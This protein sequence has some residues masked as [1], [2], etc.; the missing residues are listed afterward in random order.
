VPPVRVPLEL[1]LTVADVLRAVRDDARPFALVGE[2]ADSR[3]IVSS[4]PVRVVEGA[5]A[6]DVLDGTGAC[7]DGVCGGWFGYLGYGLGAAIER[8]PPPPPRPVP[9]PVASLG[10]YDHVWRQDRAGAW[11]FEALDERALPRLELVRARAFELSDLEPA[12]GALGRHVAAVAECVERIAAGE[13]F[14]ANV[15]LRL[16]GSFQGD[17]AEAFLAGAAALEPRHGA[18][19][20]LGAGRAVLSFSPELFLRRRGDAVVTSPIKGTAPRA[21]G[22]DALLASAKDAAEHVMIV[23][24]SRNDLGRVARWGSV[25]PGAIRAEPHPGLW[26]LVTDVRARLREG[27]TDAGLVR[28]AF[29]PG[30]VTGAPKIQALKVIADLEG[31]QREAYTGAIGFAS[32]HA[33]LQLNVAI[34]TLELAGGRAWL[35]CGG[36]IVADSDPQAELREALGK[37]API[38][39]ALGARVPE[40]VAVTPTAPPP[41]WPRRPDPA[42]GL[43]ETIAVRDGR[44]VDAERHL[45]RL[46]ASARALYAIDAPVELPAEAP[47]GRLRVLLTPDGEVAV[48][49]LPE[50]AAAAEVALEPRSLAGGLGRHK[51]LDRPQDPAWLAVDLDGAVLEAAWANVW[52]EDGEGALLTPPADGRILP[53]ITRERLLALHGAREAALTL[54]DLESARAILLSSSVRLVTPAALGGAGGPT[55]RSRELAARL[56]EDPAISMK[57][58][59]YIR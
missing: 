12:P 34:R 10:F 35:G 44:P 47:D 43:L 20:D 8:L 45:A 23:D 22:A 58:R 28:A 9:L 14:Q 3:A 49:S 19:V 30:S 21:A 11:W 29:P 53:G 40:P 36:G 13:L 41:R 15:T 18:F 31:S 38:A 17:A 55:S 50:P 6:L 48:E 1:D 52:I 59:S 33:G 39:R 46:A 4:N 32:P 42:R 24:L 5:A 16:E 51:W 7:G 26:H 54:A 57:T 27:T 56:R 2:W 37:V 25:E